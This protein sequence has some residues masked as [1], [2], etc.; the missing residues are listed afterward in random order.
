M[1]SASLGLR[2]TAPVAIPASVRRADDI[3]VKGRA[4]TLTRFTGWEDTEIDLDLAVPV[5]DGLDQY[6]QAAHEL[7]G[8]STIALTAEPGVYR[9]VKHCEVS[10]LR[11]ELSGWGFFTARLTCQP[12]SYLSEGL[13][14]VTMSESGTITNPGLLDADP[15]II[16][17]G[18]G[19]LSLTV[20]KTVHQVN[21]PAGSITLDSE[22]LVTHAHGK[23]QT[24]ALTETFPTFK[25]GL[26]RI[27]L[28]AGISKIVITPNWR[29]P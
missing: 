13:K 2:L 6:R 19:M 23:V 20:N 7:T 15:I 1:S 29:N 26:N 21:S 25:P 28:G 17:T 9:K 4:G 3:E 18:T 27:T 16:V 11:R 22:R 14:P 12:F 8:S 24:D 10:E 5:R